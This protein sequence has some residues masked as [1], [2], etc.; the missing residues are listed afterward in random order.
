MDRETQKQKGGKR[1]RQRDR[2]L[3]TDRD[4]KKYM[5]EREK[6]EEIERERERKQQTSALYGKLLHIYSLQ[7]FFLL[8]S[9]I[10]HRYSVCCVDSSSKGRF[11]EMKLSID[12]LAPPRA[13]WAELCALEGLSTLMD[14]ETHLIFI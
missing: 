9:V 4:R 7:Y 13:S 10:K 11:L 6:K 8:F 1:E 5:T 14:L 12:P 3:Q 2:A